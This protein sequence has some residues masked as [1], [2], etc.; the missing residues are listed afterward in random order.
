M[1]EDDSI[2]VT[3]LRSCLKYKISEAAELKNSPSLATEQSNMIC[4]LTEEA[5]MLHIISKELFI[6]SPID[7]DRVNEVKAKLKTLDI[8]GSGE[9]AANAAKRIAK[10]LIEMDNT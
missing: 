10:K 3:K 4:K 6:Q 9:Q 7:Y 2:S 1:I 5:K 8:L